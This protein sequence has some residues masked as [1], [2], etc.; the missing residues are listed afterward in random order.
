MKQDATDQVLIGLRPLVLDWLRGVKTFQPKKI[1]TNAMRN[2]MLLSSLKPLPPPL[3]YSCLA[4]RISL[5]STQAMVVEFSS[6]IDRTLWL[7][8]PKF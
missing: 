4:R 6:C 8:R 1:K 2:P 5:I 7:K 3:H